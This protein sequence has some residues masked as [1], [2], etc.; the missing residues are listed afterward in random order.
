MRC[1]DPKLVPPISVHALQN[2]QYLEHANQTLF[3]SVHHLINIRFDGEVDCP[4][5][6]LFVVKLRPREVTRQIY[7]HP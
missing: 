4:D 6:I 7:T 1:F 3:I 5:V 2:L